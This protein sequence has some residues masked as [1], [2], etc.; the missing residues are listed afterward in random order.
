MKFIEWPQ[1]FGTLG[2]Y[3]FRKD[4]IFNGKNSYFWLIF[5]RSKYVSLLLACMRVLIT[6][7]LFLVWGRGSCSW[8]RLNN[9]F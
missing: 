9:F 7:S 6:T 3:T 1:T 5:R 4:W 2:L 8:I